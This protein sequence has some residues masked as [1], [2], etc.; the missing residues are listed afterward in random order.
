MT[1]VIISENIRHNINSFYEFNN[2]PVKKTYINHVSNDSLVLDLYVNVT[3]ICLLI[4]L[5][6]FILHFF[7]QKKLASFSLMI[8]HLLHLLLLFVMKT[9]RTL[10]EH[11]VWCSVLTFLKSL[12]YF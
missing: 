7:K 11:F 10:C 1:R 6:N 4:H 12:K 3:D 5:R 9:M 8:T 2:N